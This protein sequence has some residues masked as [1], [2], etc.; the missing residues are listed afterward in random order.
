MRARKSA[1]GGRPATLITEPR[2]G[3]GFGKVP[4]GFQA[5]DSL[6]LSRCM[7]LDALR[8]AARCH[9]RPLFL[10]RRRLRLA[11]ASPS[12]RADRVAGAGATHRARNG[13]RTRTRIRTCCRCLDALQVFG[14]Q[15]DPP[16]PNTILNNQGPNPNNPCH[17]ARAGHMFER[18]RN[19]DPRSTTL[20]CDGMPPSLRHRG[21][22]GPSAQDADPTRLPGCR[23]RSPL[24]VDP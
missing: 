14:N 20:D 23:E 11:R 1:R 6:K 2:R 13:V 9:C 8:A 7:C 15:Q 3:P 17:C 16:A 18:G 24:N 5:D 22:Q 12:E 4:S 21:D 10:R 19:S